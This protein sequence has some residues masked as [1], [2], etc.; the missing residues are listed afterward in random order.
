M[1]ILEGLKA[2]K[3][4]CFNCGNE[5]KYDLNTFCKINE[6]KESGSRIFDDEPDYVPFC[7][8]C[9]IKIEP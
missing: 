1:E 5:N 8:W 3:R 2:E 6:L 9:I 7:D 4:K